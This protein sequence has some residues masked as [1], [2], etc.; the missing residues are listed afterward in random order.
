[1]REC[2]ILFAVAA[3]EYPR[4][5]TR[6][7]K[8]E[9]QP[10]IFDTELRLVV[11]TGLK[12]RTVA[13]LRRTLSRVPGS[14]IFF[15]THQEYLTHNFQ[16]PVYYNDFAVWVS[17]A[18]R[19]EALAEKLAAIDLLAFTTIRELRE[20]ILKTLDD[21]AASNGDMTQECRLDEAFHFCRSRSFVL[22]TGIVANDVP[23][24]FAKL[25]LITDASLYFHFFE[26]RLRLGRRTSD[27][28]RWL[29]DRGRGD[30]AEAIDGLNPYIRTLDELKQDIIRIGQ[31]AEGNS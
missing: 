3:T 20:A 10:F 1:M 18:L 28:S 24:F 30:L 21:Y 27:F 13:D 11:L 31:E 25:P 26:A 23:E 2:P 4:Y 17:Q 29:K 6:M 7:A 16:K 15:H 8:S 12:V 9:Q 5:A 19:E 14:S 22:P